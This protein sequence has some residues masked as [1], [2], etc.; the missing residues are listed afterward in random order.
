[1]IR[2]LPSGDRRTIRCLELFPATFK[3]LVGV[4]EAYLR[5]LCPFIVAL[6]A[7]LKYGRPI[8]VPRQ[9]R[10]SRDEN[11]REWSE[12]PSN[13]FHFHILSSGRKRKMEKPGTETVWK[14]SETRKQQIRIEIYR[15]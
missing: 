6:L 9:V 12:K 2:W 3:R 5:G 10:S 11:E 7:V 13:R 8:I 4:G 14:N 1:M 15:Y